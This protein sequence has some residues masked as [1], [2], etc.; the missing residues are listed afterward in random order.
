MNINHTYICFLFSYSFPMLS[1]AIHIFVVFWTFLLFFSNAE[2]CN[3]YI[4]CVFL[5]SFSPI[6]F[7]CWAVQII[8]LLCFGLLDFSPILFQCWAVQSRTASASTHFHRTAW[9]LLMIIQHNKRKKKKEEGKRKASC[10]DLSPANTP[11]RQHA[12]PHSIAEQQPSSI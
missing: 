10:P 6:L 5:F 8:Y 9:L 1:S 7:Q 11:R 3:P 12:F 2:Q 4:C